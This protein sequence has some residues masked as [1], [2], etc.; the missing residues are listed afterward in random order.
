MGGLGLE[1]DAR[2]ECSGVGWSGSG[3]WVFPSYWGW[4]ER[5][6]RQTDGHRDR[7]LGSEGLGFQIEKLQP[8]KPSMDQGSS[9]QVV[10]TQYNYGGHFLHTL[11]IPTARH[12]PL[13]KEGFITSF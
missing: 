7:K 12:T 8:P 6:K 9:V 1:R 10:N 2:G 11:S 4:E 5:K 3:V 13:P